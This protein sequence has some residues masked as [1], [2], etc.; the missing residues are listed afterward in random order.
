MV[1]SGA[2]NLYNNKNA[3]DELNVFPVPDGDTGT[4][5]SLTAQSMAQE[6]A[7][8]DG[9]TLTKAAD[10]MSFA[11]L[12]GARGNSGVIMSQ[13]FRGISRSFKGKTECGA[14]EL[15]SALKDG[16]DAAYKAV[17]NPTEGTILTVAREAAAGAKEASGG[18]D[19][20]SVVETAVE[21]GNKALARTTEML[22]VLKQANVV[23]AGGQGWMYVLEGMLSYLQSGEITAKIG[24]EE[25]AETKKTAQAAVSG[26]EIKFRY[27]TEFII[28][29]YESGAS[30]D[31]FRAA[32]ADKGDCQLV[33]DDDEV[34]KVHIHTNHP[35]FVL[36][37]AV[38]I[39][40][41]IN[42]KIDNMKHQHRE[43][44]KGTLDLSDGKT[45]STVTDGKKS[46][47]KKE[48]EPKPK[49]EKEPK[50]KKEAK[51]EPPKT[52]GF[53]AVC[54]GK[55]LAEILT[56]MGVDRIIEG[57]QTMN[58]ST[59]DIVKA[60]KKVKA[61]TV[62]VFPNNKNI[63]MAAQQAAQI[64]EDRD[65]VVIESTSYP[66]C[67]SAMIAF[68]G[69]KDAEANAGA[70][71]RAIG[72]V[73]T[74]QLTYAVRDTEIDGKKIKKNDILG[75]VEGKITRT[76]TDLDEV[77][78]GVVAEITDGDTEIITVYCGKDVKKQQADRMQKALEAKYESDEIEVSFK[79]GGQP[80]YYYIV[81]A[82]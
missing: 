51:Q 79:R 7:D 71:R 55:G 34:C 54:A 1:I 48:K 38:K 3:V 44:I 27:C 80:I 57:G 28:E 4:N 23:D 26:E 76:G 9:L 11:T 15:A 20:V 60:V 47:P 16:S 41:M 82:E 10:K 53:A 43:I 70:M 12:R 21:R 45:P 39:G 5:M 69:Q 19:V 75:M 73:A 68:N 18:G 6:L 25:A 52:Y 37:E 64:L 35:G 17:M 72:K 42:L 67:V 77:L 33:I 32:I 22:P 24:G 29:K 8:T 2:N 13:F 66:Q 46:K 36:E 78:A 49:K 59:D 74:A 58:P 61:Q 40:E 50:P 62:F 31:D 30:V 65:I 63:I 81:S 56:D 14:S